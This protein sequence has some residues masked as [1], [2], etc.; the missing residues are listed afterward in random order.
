[1]ILL[2]F[3]LTLASFSSF[4]YC[5]LSPSVPALAAPLFLALTLLLGIAALVALRDATSVKRGKWT[6]HS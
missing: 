2:L 4:T 5:E 1:M 3:I 6:V